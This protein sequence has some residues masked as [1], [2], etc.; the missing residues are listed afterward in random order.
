MIHQFGQ[1]LAY[2][3]PHLHLVRQC[4]LFEDLVRHRMIVHGLILLH[5]LEWGFAQLFNTLDH[6]NQSRKHIAFVH[7]I[8]GIFY[9][10]TSTT[11]YSSDHQIQTDGHTMFHEFD[12]SVAQ[13]SGSLVRATMEHVKQGGE[14]CAF[15]YS[16]PEG[17]YEPASATHSSPNCQTE[18]NDHTMFHE[19]HQ[20]VAHHLQGLV[21]APA[22]H[23]T[24]GV[25]HIALKDFI[26]EFIYELASMIHPRCLIE[27]NGRT[28]FRQFNQRIA[29]LLLRLTRPQPST[30]Y[31][32][33]RGEHI[34]FEHLIS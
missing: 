19:F 30:E 33:Q 23:L 32:T 9:E 28:M 3:L 29:Y 22:K 27:T 18:I 17:I 15:E 8:P 25:E 20:R 26:P 11:H 7:L 24:Q 16:A 13:W 2:Q 4:Q 5:V 14:H 21:R 31:V 6:V 1:L 34:T 12:Q 10:P